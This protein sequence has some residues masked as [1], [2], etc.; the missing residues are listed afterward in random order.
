MKEK[1]VAV[2]K[3]KR[4][5]GV[6]HEHRIAEL[7]DEDIVHLMRPKRQGA[8][9]PREHVVEALLDELQAWHVAQQWD[10]EPVRV[11][12]IERKQA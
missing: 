3:M 9:Q 8:L 5:I 11:I 4:A 10:R 12:L 1:L 7:A 6:H 2:N